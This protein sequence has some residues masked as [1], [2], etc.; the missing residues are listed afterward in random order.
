MAVFSLI[1][2]LLK[3]VLLLIAIGGAVVVFRAWKAKRDSKRF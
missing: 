2:K 1:G 3:W